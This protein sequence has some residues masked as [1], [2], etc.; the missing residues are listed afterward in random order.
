MMMIVTYTNNIEI[1]IKMNGIAFNNTFFAICSG[2][3]RLLMSGL[4][5]KPKTKNTRLAKTTLKG[6]IDFIFT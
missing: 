4:A 3:A 2:V 1:K 5:I 6:I